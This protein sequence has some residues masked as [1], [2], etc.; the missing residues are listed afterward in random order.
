MFRGIDSKQT[1]DALT[2]ATRHVP[3]PLRPQLL[4][5]MASAVL[6]A[7]VEVVHPC[8]VFP[9]GKAPSAT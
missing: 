4:S 6:S 7:P 3:C 1:Q 5:T 8:L 2:P 9:I